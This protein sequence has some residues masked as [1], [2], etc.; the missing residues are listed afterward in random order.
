[1]AELDAAERD[2]QKTSALNKAERSFT[3][4]TGKQ[5][6]GGTNEGVADVLAQGK[7]TD[8]ATDPPMESRVSNQPALSPDTAAA[9]AAAKSAETDPYSQANL[10]AGSNDPQTPDM[11]GLLRVAPIIKKTQDKLTAD[12]LT[13]EATKG[14]NQLLANVDATNEKNTEAPNLFGETEEEM[15]EGDKYWNL[16]DRKALRKRI[17]E[18]VAAGNFDGDGGVNE[19]AERGMTELGIGKKEMNREIQQER[20]SS[21]QTKARENRAQRERSQLGSYQ[22]FYKRMQDPNRTLSV[23]KLGETRSLYSRNAGLRKAKKLRKMGFTAAAN[24]AANDWAKSADSNAPAVASRKYLA[25]RDAVQARA[26][27]ARNTNAQLQQ[28]M[29]DRLMGKMKNDPNFFPDLQGGG[30]NKFQEPAVRQPEMVQEPLAQTGDGMRTM[31]K[32]NSFP[33]GSSN[34]RQ[35]F[36]NNLKALSSRGALTPEMYAQAREELGKYEGVSAEKFD[37]VMKKN[38]IRP[39]N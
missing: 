23:G 9:N 35:D 13:N 32:R 17:T 37:S 5:D 39:S 24:E 22:D 1:M 19:L 18:Q 6:F 8:P 4:P 14:R 25:A 16:Q 27:R 2:A 11:T 3:N 28:A 33:E 34:M 30:G 21:L 15:T 38:R 31:E 26:D 12:A 10:D 7:L 20:V 36:F 29:A